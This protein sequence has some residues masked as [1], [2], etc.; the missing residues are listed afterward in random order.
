MHNQLFQKKK[1]YVF[2]FSQNAS[3]I[4]FTSRQLTK[5]VG[6]HPGA[7]VDVAALLIWI[8]AAAQAPMIAAIKMTA[9]ID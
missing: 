7:A 8:D 3:L 1:F 4:T 6:S 5:V 9:G 2:F